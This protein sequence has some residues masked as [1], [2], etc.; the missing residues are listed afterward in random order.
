MTKRRILIGGLSQEVHSFSPHKTIA[1][2]FIVQ[3]GQDILQDDCGGI[4]GGIIKAARA[5]E[6]EIIPSIAAR[7]R[8]GGP[9][10]QTVY[11]GFKEEIVEAARLNSI[12][13]VALGL[14]GAM[15]TEA[16][17]D[18][19]GDLLAA[20]RQVVGPDVPIAA[21]FDLHGH[22]TAHML[23]HSEF[24]T[25]CKNC[26]HSDLVETGERVFNRVFDIFE[27]R[28]KP[29]TAL[30]K[31]PMLL[32]GKELTIEE[33]IKSIQ[34]YAR[35]LER[36]HSSLI[37]ISIFNVQHFLDGHDLGQ[38]VVVVSDNDPSLAST[39]VNDF[40]QRLWDVRDEVVA[41]DSSIPEAMEIIISNPQK[42]P[43]VLGDV[44][45]RVSAGSP[46]DSTA[47]LKHLLEND[48]TLNAAI[49]IT[50]P[51]AVSEAMNAG[52]GAEVTLKVGGRLTPGFEPVDVTGVVA[53]L[54]SGEGPIEVG[55][56]FGADE[57][58]NPGKTAV[59][60]VGKIRLLLTTKS[61][62]IMFPKSFTSQGIEI[63]ELDFM[64][65][66]SGMHFKFLFKNIAEPLC[67]DTPGMTV[68]RPEQFPFKLGRPI[69]PLDNI[70]YRPKTPQL[71]TGHGVT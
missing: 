71:F 1:S 45:D 10:L 23:T 4:L 62:L 68:Y 6:V 36:E 12:D 46:G 33:P 30:G 42:R 8:P 21:G 51:Q 3:R 32:R 5:Q 67:V 61:A 53:H 65:V 55:G 37:D 34:A 22:L 14:H 38:A 15:Q 7:A 19:E 27:K 43:Y 28:I 11:E 31:V 18:P 57:T 39:V 66:K 24:C 52:L 40:C 70:D 20:I 64:V 54:G 26:P 69:Y 59:L 41:H 29:V 13:A 48:L 35:K 44:G 60:H 2:D 16:L 47:I 63:R 50:D 49:S 58:G 25:A 17:E 56:A 9:V